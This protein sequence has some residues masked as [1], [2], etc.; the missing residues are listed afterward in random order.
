MSR[1][2]TYLAS[3]ILVMSLCADAAVGG[4]YYEDPP[5]GWTYIYTGD[6]AA[7][8]AGFNALDGTWSHG[9]GSDR[10]DGTEIGSGRPGGVSIL[11]DGN[12]TFARLQD[13]GDPRNYGMGDP[14]NRKI[15]FGHSITTDIGAIANTLLDDGVTIS[16]RARLSTTPPLDS[17]FPPGGSFHYPWPIGG[18]GYVLHNG[19]K[20]NFGIHQPYNNKLISFALSLAS[21]SYVLSASGLT[22]NKLNGRW[23]TNAVDLQDYDLGVVNFLEIADLTVWHEFW[24][25]IRADTSGGG[26]HKVEVYVDGSPAPTEF[27]VTAG[28]GH[29]FQDSYISLGVG[30]TPQSGAI[31]V[32][33]FAYTEGIAAP[34]PAHPEKASVP[35]PRS[36]AMVGRELWQLSWSPGE[37]A[38]SH[39][40]Y[41]GDNFDDVDTGAGS[42]F[43]GNQTATY[44]NVGLPGS[45]YPDGLILDRT[46]YWRVD[47]VEVDGWTIH[48]GDVW[49]FTVVDA[50]TIEYQVSS[51]DDDGYAA[52][53]SLQN[54]GWDYLKVGASAFAQPPYYVCGMVFRNV[55]I[56]EIISAH[57]RIRSHNSHLTDM[58]Y[59]KIEAEAADSADAFGSFRRMDALPRTI[60]SVNWDHYK[61]WAEDTWYNSPDISDVIQEIISRSGWLSWSGSLAILYSTRDREGGY[62]NLSSYDRGSDYAPK[63]EI[64]YAP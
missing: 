33:F 52:G 53:E 11:S 31:D 50:A 42:A 15:L 22:M 44:F 63:L 59:A 55:D 4:V 10:W 48:K 56:P 28:T 29:D 23:P 19:G 8:G 21:D 58:V 27:D 12:V 51:S 7:S 36:G 60:A 41:L 6:S 26:T 34:I 64:T 30:S 61:P 5:G 35:T 17:L 2:L 37:G 25:T 47:E 16:F 40:V 14:S 62:R 57:L 46:Y 9:N 45:P 39:D 54:L 3:L 43:Q 38:I 18:D 49:S 20:D 32:D 1:K 13:T 24:I